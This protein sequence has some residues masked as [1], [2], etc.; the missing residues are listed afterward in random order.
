MRL[1]H[2]TLVI[3]VAAAWITS[4]RISPLHEYLGYGA[5]AAALTRFIWGF[6]GSAYARFSQ[7]VRSPGPTWRYLREVAAGKAPRYLGHNPL[8]GWMVVAL[9][10]CVGALV[11]TGW[12]YTTDMFWGYG[13]LASLHGWLG[14]LLLILIAF[15]VAGVVF[16]SF[17]HRENLVAAMF[18]G[19][20]MPPEADDIS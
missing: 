16:T 14:W 7:F 15:H 13:W 11:F 6:A 12:L 20:K 4:D 3:T 1:L 10:S 19:K 2:W 18:S 9:L 5:G 8:G 17:Q